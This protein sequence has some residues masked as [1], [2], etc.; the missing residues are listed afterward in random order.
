MLSGSRPDKRQRTGTSGTALGATPSTASFKA[1]M[2]PGLVPQH[3][4][5]ILMSPLLAN[6]SMI[7]AI[8]SGV[9]SYSPNSFGNPAFGCAHTRVSA[10]R[11]SSAT[12]GRRSAAPSAQLRPIMNG[13]ACCTEF[14]KAST[15]CPDKVRPDASVIVPEIITGRV[16]PV[17][18]KLCLIAK[19]AAFA[20][21]VSKIV[22]TIRKSTPP[23][24]SA[25]A[26]SS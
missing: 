17:F 25:V 13:S 6:S 4:P 14:Q 16:T 26:A 15:V 2:W 22:S 5:V 24:I 7:P 9:S 18:A 8:C 11:A 23:W 3:P 12:Y 10:M 20:F 1:R 19:I 21:S